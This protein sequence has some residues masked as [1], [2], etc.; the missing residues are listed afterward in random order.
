MDFKYKVTVIV[1]VYNV[2][3]YLRGCLDSLVNQTISHDKM[4]VLLINDGS[5]D[6]SLAIC[7]EYA[8]KYS[9][10]KVFSKENEGLSATR[11][12]GI[13]RAQGKY[14]IYLD[15]DDTFTPETLYEITRFFDSVYDKVDVVTYLIQ[16]YRNGEKMKIHYRY[17]YLKESG[18]YPLDLYPYVTQTTIN[19][20]VKNMGDDNLLFNTDPNFRHEDQ[21]YCSELLKAKRCIGYCNKG[22]YQYNRSN[23]SSIVSTYFQAYYLFEPTIKYFEDLFNSFEGEI[24]PY[25]QTMFFHDVRWKLRDN[26]LLPYHYE[27][28][29]YKV[30]LSRIKALLDRVD[31]DVIMSYPAADNY[32]KLF[33]L[34]MK[35]NDDTCPIIS[36]NKIELYSGGKKLYSRKN[37]EIFLKRILVKNN[38]I[39]IVGYFKSPFFSYIQNVKLYAKKNGRFYEL[40]KVESS[41][42]YHKSNEKTE[43]F[44]QLV[45]ET[46]IVDLTTIEFV[47]ELEGLQLPTVYYN[48]NTTPFFENHTKE[49]AIDGISIKQVKNGFI[50]KPIVDPEEIADSITAISER[51][52]YSFKKIRDKYLSLPKK[53]VW[54]YYDNYTVE[55]DNGYYQFMNDARKKDGIERYYI[56][57]NFSYDVS[58]FFPPDLLPN[59]IEFGTPEHQMM[60]LMAEKILTSFIESESLSPFELSEQYQINDIFNAELIYLQHGVLH[61][62]LPWYYTP[63]GVSVD[64]VVISTPFEIDNFSTNY[65]FNKSDLI[66]VGMP[67]YKYIDRSAENPKNRILFAPS[68]RSY[69][70]GKIL[71]GN[72]V[73][74][75]N[76]S[77]LLSS[78]YYK[79]LMKF[80]SSRKLNDSLEK[81]NIDLDLKLHPNFLKV[82]KH[83][84]N[85]ESKR[86]HLAPAN[87]DLTQYSLFIT[88]FSSY[89]FDYAYLSRAMMYY[90]PDYMEFKSGMNRYRKLDLPFEKAFGNLTTYPEAAVDEVIRIIENDF[91]PDPVFKER[92]DNFYLPMDDCEEKIYK[93]LLEET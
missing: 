6:N 41:A 60:Y 83:L 55:K 36:W 62:H 34:R 22:E 47:V 59:V 39:K 18:V 57:S 61:A 38:T 58:K 74:E 78:N 32:Q 40:D 52:D 23:E 84:I 75:G 68:W 67:R 24:P 73:R 35:S 28:D 12:Y 51:V 88:D 56:L 70:I 50:C 81:H 46:E 3:E 14:M 91:I 92:M 11:N 64:K 49:Y 42:S 25:Y 93:Y 87:V 21:A 29:E 77:R 82:Y 79:N 71:Q 30:A 72:A 80:L 1:P 54:L 9:F 31:N 8:E 4:E 45:Y 69:L 15:S 16:P 2:E 63:N 19:I 89:S 37:I 86:I 65:G 90:V 48:C 5:T 76:D 85:I 17:A 20:C 33:W 44:F 26:I 43:K 7:N 27:E 10:F 53:R 13:K 66:P